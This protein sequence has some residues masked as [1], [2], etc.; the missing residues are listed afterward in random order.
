MTATGLWQDIGAGEN[1]S[2]RFIRLVFLLVAG[3]VFIFLASIQETSLVSRQ[4]TRREN[5][6]GRV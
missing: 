3:V 4:S 2:T 5:Q 1:F 6:N